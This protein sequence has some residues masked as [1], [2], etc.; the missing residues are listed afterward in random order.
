ML[1]R[2]LIMLYSLCAALY[3]MA[4]AE[5]SQPPCESTSLMNGSLIGCFDG[6]TNWNQETPATLPAQ[7][8]A[9]GTIEFT[10]MLINQLQ[11]GIG[12]STLSLSKGSSD[13]LV[14]AEAYGKKIVSLISKTTAANIASKKAKP[15]MA[16]STAHSLFN[17]KAF[18][19]FTPFSPLFEH[20]S[21]EPINA[22]KDTPW[23]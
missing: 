10:A 20:D 19:A 17:E 7:I 14:N 6:N 23:K 22:M 8:N 16:R 2:I 5:E 9:E 15:Q 3:S 4:N 11:A 18:D 13:G 12:N 21:F 1:V